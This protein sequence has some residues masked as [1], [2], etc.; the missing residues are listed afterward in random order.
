[1]EARRKTDEELALEALKHRQLASNAEQEIRWLEEELRRWKNSLQFNTDMAEACLKDL[2]ARTRENAYQSIYRPR[3]G[4][5][6]K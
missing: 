2:H 3:N 5:E 6:A 4:T 1:M